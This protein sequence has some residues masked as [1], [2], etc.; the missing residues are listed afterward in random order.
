MRE[1]TLER[2]GLD[3]HLA[4]MSSRGTELNTIDVITLENKKEENVLKIIEEQMA[5]LR[6][7][8]FNE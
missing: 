2:V 1:F 8:V 3:P 7:K 5:V 4:L 6:Q